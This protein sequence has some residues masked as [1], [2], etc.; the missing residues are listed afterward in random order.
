MKKNLIV[1]VLA[2]FSLTVYAQK[3][4]FAVI[5]T[6]NNGERAHVEWNVQS[7]TFE[8]G[9][10]KI[11]LNPEATG[12]NGYLLRSEETITSIIIPNGI[13]NIGNQSFADFS[14][15]TSITLPQSITKIEQ[16]AF[17]GCSSLMN[18]TIPEGVIDIEPVAFCDCSKLTS[19]TIPQ[20]VT[21]IGPAAFS[22][23]SN[24]KEFNG[25]FVSEDKRCL[26]I[27]NE[28]ISFAPKNI[29]NYTIPEEVTSI[30]Y[31]V[32]RSCSTLTNITIP[33]SVSH[34]D[35]FAFENCQNLTS[36]II[37]QSVISIAKRAFRDCSSLTSV[38][39]KSIEPLELSYDVFEGT[40]SDL[41]IY[42][43]K[44]SVDKYKTAKEW[45]E[46][47]DCIEPYEFK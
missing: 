31:G 13:T 39:C 27:N 35:E 47:A 21:K 23:C 28:L 14:N 44:E 12:I 36:V 40:A 37:P 20:S 34:I 4:D 33:Q 15:L 11:V 45:S 7:H 19:I 5:Y 30:G 1:A 3:E 18:I 38:Y 46:Y 43:P 42:V 26:I 25:K 24:L 16:G 8:N 6:T 9:K 10:G 32:F 2:L 22:G 41:K 17:Y 29:T